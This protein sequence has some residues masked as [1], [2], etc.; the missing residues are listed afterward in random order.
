MKLYELSNEYQ[1]LL[2]EVCTPTETG[3]IN[4][5]AVEELNEIKDSI[6]VKAIAIAK[7]IRNLHAECMAVNEAREAMLARAKKLSN[8]M[9]SL[10]YYLETNMAACGITEISSSPYF[11]IKLKKCPPSVKILDEGL[12][13]PGYLKTK[14]IMT[15]DKV[16]IAEE[17]KAGNLVPG[18]TLV[19]KNRVEIK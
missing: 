4:D 13:E 5:L 18:A 6:E 7:Y 14:T 2:D 8:K 19:Q 1:K 17:I 11:T 3:E 16:M 15:V 12:I 9:E 10:E